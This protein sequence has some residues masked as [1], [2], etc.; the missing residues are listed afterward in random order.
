MPQGGKAKGSSSKYQQ[1]GFN[2]PLLKC[3]FI[4]AK[5]RGAA[6][7]LP[8]ARDGGTQKMAGCVQGE[9]LCSSTLEKPPH[10]HPESPLVPGKCKVVRTLNLLFPR[11]PLSSA[12]QA[13]VRRNG[14][15]AWMNQQWPHALRWALSRMAGRP[16][17][18]CLRGQAVKV[19]LVCWP[20]AKREV[21]W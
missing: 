1:F 20:V 16:C 19:M 10:T 6:C 18:S 2:H 17:P 13:C 3:R 5:H 9:I 4:Q 12:L 7:E 21:G 8:V 15:G 14:L 11:S